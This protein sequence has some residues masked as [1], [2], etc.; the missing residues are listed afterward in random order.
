MTVVDRF[1]PDLIGIA[2]DEAA[3]S[4]WL[5]RACIRASRTLGTI[6]IFTDPSTGDVLLQIHERDDC[7]AHLVEA[8]VRLDTRAVR[9]LT[10]LL[11]REVA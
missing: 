2:D 7:G 1:D 4:G 9:A 8:A 10:L 3:L 5:R 11:E 6:D